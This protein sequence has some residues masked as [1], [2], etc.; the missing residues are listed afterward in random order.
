MTLPFDIPDK[1]KRKYQCFVCGRQYEE[2]HEYKD[3]IVETHEEGTDYVRCPLGRCGAPIRDVKLHFKAKHPSEPMPKKGALRATLWRDIKKGKVKKRKPK[4]RQGWYESTKMNKK[5]RYD[6][7]WEEVVFECL[8]MDDD[9]LA[10]EVEPIKIPYIHKGKAHDYLPDILI[11]FVDGHRELWEIKPSS[12]TLLEVNKDKW[13]AA[14]KVCDVRGW[15]FETVTE[16]AI[17]RLK[18]KIQLQ[19][20]IGK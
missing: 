3:H 6:S 7:S 2:Y 19:K 4:F 16:K 17:E 8:D 11:L 9:V 10:F 1:N 18:K 15:K 12:Q 14:E 20:N 5:F 13:F